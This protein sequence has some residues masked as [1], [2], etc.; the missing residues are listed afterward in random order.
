[1]KLEYLIKSLMENLQNFGEVEMTPRSGDRGVDLVGK[2]NM[3]SNVQVGEVDTRIDFKA[4][5][6]NKRLNSNISGKDLSRLASRVDD[7]VV[8]LFFTTSYYSKKA[9]EENLS[10]YP[11]R[12]FCGKDIVEL[13]VQ[14]D[15][16]EDN[17]LSDSI[18]EKINST[19]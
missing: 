4:Q 13:L 18:V 15:L 3:M 11:I 10:T 7:G 5:I 2:I 8:G 17:K 1:M 12:T 16:T 19:I 6:K 14:T 9:Q